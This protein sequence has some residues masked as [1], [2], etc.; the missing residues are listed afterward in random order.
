MD[1]ATKFNRLSGDMAFRAFRGNQS[2]NPDDEAQLFGLIQECF[3]NLEMKSVRLS[4]IPKMFEGAYARPLTTK[5]KIY[6]CITCN[7]FLIQRRRES[8]RHFQITKRLWLAMHGET[9]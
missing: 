6:I 4:E 9:K 8:Y 3:T 7:Y 5:R 2:G 1:F